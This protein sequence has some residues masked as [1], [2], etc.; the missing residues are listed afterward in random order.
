MTYMTNNICNPIIKMVLDCDYS[1]L[2]S[3]GLFTFIDYCRYTHG[4]NSFSVFTDQCFC[5]G[6]PRLW[7]GSSV[8]R[9]TS[10]G[11]LELIYSILRTGLSNWALFIQIKTS[12][13]ILSRVILPNAFLTKR[14]AGYVGFEIMHIFLFC[15]FT[16]VW[17]GFIYWLL[18]IGFYHHVDNLVIS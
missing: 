12:P 14:L 8:Y 1:G 10:L 17:N 18:S 5:Y 9:I 16:S 13:V 15:N 2:Y 3:S 11:L 4:P 6:S 7:V